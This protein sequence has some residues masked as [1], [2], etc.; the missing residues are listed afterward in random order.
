MTSRLTIRSPPTS[1][2]LHTSQP[3]DDNLHCRN[4]FVAAVYGRERR[5]GVVICSLFIPRWVHFASLTVPL[6]PNSLFSSPLYIS[7]SF[8]PPFELEVYVE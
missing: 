8:I 1:P 7:S 6:F 4:A 2:L 5:A 3:D